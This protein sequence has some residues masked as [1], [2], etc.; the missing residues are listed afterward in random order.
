MPSRG[1]KIDLLKREGFRYHFDREVYYNQRLKKI[2]SLEWIEDHDEGWLK[3][4]IEEPGAKWKFYFNQEPSV[5]VGELIIR[6]L[7]R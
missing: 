5:T 6:E 2:F 1:R 3:R 7:S 4:G